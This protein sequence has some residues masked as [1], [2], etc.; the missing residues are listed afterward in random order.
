[1]RKK[2][3]TISSLPLHPSIK[4]KIDQAHLFLDSF[5]LKILSKE[6]SSLPTGKFPEAT[7]FIRSRYALNDFVDFSSGYKIDNKTDSLAT[8]NLHHVSRN[9]CLDLFQSSKVSNENKR[10][11]CHDSFSTWFADA[12]YETVRKV[13]EGIKD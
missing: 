13:Y 5:K 4:T 8:S 11:L 3:S 1:M 2:E 9:W 10:A 12:A 6:E 7:T